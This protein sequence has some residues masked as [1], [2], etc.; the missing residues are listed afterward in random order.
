MTDSR[1][2]QMYTLTQEPK[3]GQYLALLD[4]SLVYC[5]RFS[6]IQRPGIA[7]E[8]TGQQVLASLEEFLTA[9]KIVSEWPGTRLLSG[10]TA[11]FREYELTKASLAVLKG[12]V[13]SLYQWQQ[14]R[15][16]EDLVFWGPSNQE[17]LVTIAH[18]GDAYMT[19]NESVY[20][21]L[22]GALPDLSLVRQGD[23]SASN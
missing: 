4:Q 9:E 21:S 1:R 6:L 13:T 3:G 10:A 22:T 12:A 8:A 20:R 14:P 16:P 11:T 17:W 19:L 7:L 5:T 18:E 23:E 15:L 2:R